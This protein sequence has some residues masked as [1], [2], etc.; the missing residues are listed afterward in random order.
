MKIKKDDNVLVMTGKDRGKSG[1]VLTVFPSRDRIIIDGLNIR[2]KHKRP[3]RAGQKGQRIQ[4]PAPMHI[5][6]VKILCPKCAKPVRV[7]Y[8]HT[9]AGK[10]RVCKKC[11]AEI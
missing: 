9:S 10:A 1:K 4:I 2:T 11:R 5:S 3:R 8:N 6:N 7:G